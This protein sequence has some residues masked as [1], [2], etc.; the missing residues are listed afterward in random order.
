MEA[1]NHRG[2]SVEELA[3]KAT[4]STSTLNNMLRGKSVHR[5]TAA[6]FADALGISLAV[7]LDETDTTGGASTVHEYLVAEVLT[8]WMAA[9]NGLKFQICRLRH[10]ELDREARGKRFDLREMPTDEEQRCRTLI[11]RHPTVCQAMNEH[12]NI[13]RNL[14]AFRDP[15]ESFYWVIDEWIDGESL[16]RRFRNGALD[17]SEARQLMLD[18]ANG[19]SSLHEQ[20]IVRRELSPTSIMVRSSDGR[21]ILTEFELAKLID[22]GPTVSNGQWPIDPYRAGEADTDDVDLRADIYSWARI[23]IQAVTGELPEIGME[24]ECLR[25][26]GIPDSVR[27][28]LLRSTNV[29]RSERP[30]SFSVVIPTIHQWV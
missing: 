16:H 25:H 28:A 19:L 9:S 23:G 26:A 3:E 30:E 24:E 27:D 20:G 7:L 21:A 11:K 5:K 6:A 2:L 29:F 8:D 4:F 13:V 10:M 17:I 22:R 14:T 1:M 15:V 12:P 18:I